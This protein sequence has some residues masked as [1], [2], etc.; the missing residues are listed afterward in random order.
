MAAD[1]PLFIKLIRRRRALRIGVI[2]PLFLLSVLGPNRSVNW[3]RH[4]AGGSPDESNHFAGD[5]RSDGHLR[6]IVGHQ[7]TV[8]LGHSHLAFP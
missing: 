7:V 6:F 8:A 2:R 1:K 4:Q 3:R 5:S